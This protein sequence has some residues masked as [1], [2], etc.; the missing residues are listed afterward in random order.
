LLSLRRETR[1]GYRSDRQFAGEG[2]RATRPP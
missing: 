1:P 2:A